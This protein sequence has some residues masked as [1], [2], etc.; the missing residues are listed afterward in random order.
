MQRQGAELYPGVADTSL[1]ASVLVSDHEA[2]ST[3]I[4]MMRVALED[5]DGRYGQYRRMHG[6]GGSVAPSHTQGY[7]T[8]GGHSTSSQNSDGSAQADVGDSDVG[9]GGDLGQLASSMARIGASLSRS[10]SAGG[11]LPLYYP[12]SLRDLALTQNR[13]KESWH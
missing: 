10:S 11:L 9:M 12:V 5:F 3:P 4:S 1:P 13:I 2:L 6:T 7:T 8:P